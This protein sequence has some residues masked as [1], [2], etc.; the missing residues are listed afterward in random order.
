MSEFFAEQLSRFT[1]DGTGLDRDALL[2]AAGRASARPS[3]GWVTLACA[4][5]A[6]QV[7][8]FILLWPRSLESVSVVK[9]TP[10]TRSA[11]ELND[12]SSTPEQSDLQFLNSRAFVW[13]DG[14]LPLSAPVESMVPPSPPLHALDR[15]FLSN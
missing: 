6:S 2:I 7:L 5:A 10:P 14:D 1:P 4:L 12:P 9:N 13:K 3:R 15:S 11:P 8:T